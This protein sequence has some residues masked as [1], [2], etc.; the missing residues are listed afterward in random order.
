MSPGIS[1]NEINYQYVSV[2]WLFRVKVDRQDMH[3]YFIGC[4]KKSVNL[5]NS[6]HLYMCTK[7]VFWKLNFENTM[8]MVLCHKHP[9]AGD[10]CGETRFHHFHQSSVFFQRLHS[11]GASYHIPNNN[12]GFLWPKVLTNLGMFRGS[13]IFTLKRK[14]AQTQSSYVMLTNEM[15]FLNEC[16]NSIL[17]AFYMFRSSYDHHR[18]NLLFNII[19]LHHKTRL[20]T[21]SSKIFLTKMKAGS[22]FWEKKTAASDCIQQV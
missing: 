6:E 10:G 16:F 8:S 20:T 19:Y 17:L 3:I 18:C 1:G 13:R 15:H 11:F 9:V 21:Q 22:I 2:T 4:L 7:V 14:E 5:K 12:E